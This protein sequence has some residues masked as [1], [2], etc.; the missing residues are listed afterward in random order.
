[1][2]SKLTL[3]TT[4]AALTIG[5]GGIANA[6]D[7][8]GATQDITIAADQ[9]A[10]NVPGSTSGGN[11]TSPTENPG[12]LSAPEKKATGT[13]SGTTG[14]MSD[15][16]S[17][18]VPGADADGDAK[19]QNQGSLSAPEKDAKGTGPVGAGGQTDNSA[20]NVPGSDAEGDMKT[21][22]QGSLSAPEKDKM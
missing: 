8:P 11:A 1:M 15:E 10:A 4:V 20:A 9:G 7:A 22:N 17:A 18:N 13:D 2:R 14:G 19:S 12:S 21:E 6:Q 16:S 5:F 3:M